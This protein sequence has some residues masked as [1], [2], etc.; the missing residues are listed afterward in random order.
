MTA[1]TCLGQG[2]P[3]NDKIEDFQK[4]YPDIIIEDLVIAAN[5]LAVNEAEINAQNEKYAKG[6]IH[7][8][9]RP[10][11]AMDIDPIEKWSLAHTG[12]N[13]SNESNE[14]IDTP[15]AL[16]YIDKL[17]EK[18]NQEDIPDFW[19][20]RL[21]GWVTPAKDQICGSCYIFAA[22]AAAETALIKAGA[23]PDTMDLSEQWPLNCLFPYPHSGCAGGTAGEVA[24]FL[25]KR[26]GVL[27]KESDL[28]YKGYYDD[29]GCKEDP[30][31]YWNPGFKLINFITYFLYDEDIMRSIMES[32]SVVMTVTVYRSR[33]WAHYAKGV[34]DDCSYSAGQL[35]DHQVVA[36][37]WGTEN[38]VDYWLIK[39]SWGATWGENGFMKLKRGTC[40]ANK[41]VV[42]F[43]AIETP[44]CSK[45]TPCET[46]Q[47]HCDDNESC[48]SGNCGL[49][50]CP[51]VATMDMVREPGRNHANC[52]FEAY[53]P[54][55]I[56][57]KTKCGKFDG[58]KEGLSL[59][60]CQSQQQC[61]KFTKWEWDTV[62]NQHKNCEESDTKF[63]GV[64]KCCT[65]GSF[66]LP[67]GRTNCATTDNYNL[68]DLGD[69]AGRVFDFDKPIDGTLTLSEDIEG[70][71][72]GW[73]GEWIKI[74]DSG[75]SK[76][77]KCKIEG[78]LGFP[79]KPV[80]QLDI[81]CSSDST[82]T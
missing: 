25:I 64:P 59:K 35:G 42:S 37:G 21:K 66:K 76:I 69:C 72:D 65:F 6:E 23:D 17:R 75:S 10:G 54:V 77:M 26:G 29:S 63:L 55:D 68:S 2:E 18:Y 22:F 51:T 43:V 48:L 78:G 38:G 80:T 44:I 47:G 40:G 36:V 67:N 9:E 50:N 24:E 52:C 46:G 62:L 31:P 15:E 58:T 49:K 57:I 28:P 12:F 33:K 71:R 16:S 61:R 1:R 45:E 32:G 7:Y 8:S 11:G 53:Q 74:N 81:V 3:Y 79:K 20:S 56:A 60:L 82:T 34:F 4:K 70:K 13:T 39:N 30:S 5:N 41:R 73:K 14:R 19:D 27:I